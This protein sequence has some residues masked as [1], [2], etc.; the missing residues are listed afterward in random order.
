MFHKRIVSVLAGALALAALSP[1]VN[2]QM[3]PQAQAVG[4]GLVAGQVVDADTGKGIAGAMVLMAQMSRQPGTQGPSLGAISINADSQGR[5]YFAGLPPGEYLTQTVM[6]GWVVVVG[7]EAVT[8]AQGERRTNLRL[9]L[10]RMASISGTVR[11]QSGLA[12]ANAEVFA[13]RPVAVSGRSLS[14]IQGGR[15]RTDDRGQ[16]RL[17]Q[18]LPGDYYVCVCG[19]EPLPFDGVLLSTLA[20]QPQQLLA[21]AG[22]AAV[23]GAGAVQIERPLPTVPP[24]FHPGTTLASQA[25]VVRVVKG[26]LREGIDIAVTVAPGYRVSG[27]VVG[28]PSPLHASNLRLF[29]LGD[30]SDA[31]G[32]V[33]IPPMLVQPDGR[34]DFTNVPPGAYRLDVSVRPGGRGGGPSGSA[35]MMLGSRGAQVPAPSPGPPTPGSAGDPLWGSTVVSVGT[36]DVLDVVVGLQPGLAISGRLEFK[37]NAPAPTSRDL[38]RYGAEVMSNDAGPLQRSARTTMQADGTFRI[39]GII[40]GRYALI[41]VASGSPWV[42][43]SRI[44]AGGIDITDTL[45]TVET[46]DLTDVVIT[47]SDIPYATI[48][49]RL[50][51][52]SPSSEAAPTVVIFPDDRRLWQEPFGAFRRFRATRARVDNT[53]TLPGVPGGDYLVATTPLADTD[54]ILPSVIE[55]LARTAQRIRVPDTGEVTVEVRR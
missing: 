12:V 23:A 41:P 28:A 15:G 2:G 22:R 18:M 32:L 24:T 50:V 25:E 36:G 8:L 16:Y 46:R 11:D 3:P 49:G 29:T 48:R 9:M 10:G 44:T 6:P 4:T 17:S 14:W 51:G 5:F 13:F 38:P 52:A 37:G 43:L 40:P 39:G 30:R 35:L 53:F 31:A 26:E 54:W 27:R 34:F 20:T 55:G 7:S 33:Q 1:S 42:S 19:R 47:L 45:V 21:I